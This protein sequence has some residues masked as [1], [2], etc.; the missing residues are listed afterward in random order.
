MSATP[1]LIRIH[2]EAIDLLEL[3]ERC[4]QDG[5]NIGPRLAGACLIALAV[6]WAAVDIC[7][8]IRGTYP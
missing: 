4:C 7:H 3:F 6:K 8:A 2:D 1:E 5:S